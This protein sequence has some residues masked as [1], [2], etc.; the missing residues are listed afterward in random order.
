MDTQKALETFVAGVREA[1]GPLSTEVVSRCRE[2]LEDLARTELDEPFLDATSL[3]RELY[4]DARGYLLLTHVEKGGRYRFPHD[5]GS[6]W[7]IYAVQSGE[8]EMS[9]YGRFVAEDGS[10]SLVK[11]ESY[12]MRAGESRAYLPGDIHD[13]RAI[14][15]DLSMLRFTSCDLALEDAEGRMT[16][17]LPTGAICTAK[18]R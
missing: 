7:V 4:R 6:G 1:W 9:T 5:H 12:R 16:R 17:Y 18:K 14:S 10:V 11:R 3:D 15:D 2:L 13:T 8:I